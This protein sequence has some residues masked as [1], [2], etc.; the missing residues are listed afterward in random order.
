MCFSLFSVLKWS[1]QDTSLVLNEFKEHMKR[2][3]LPTFNEIKQLQR[4]NKSLQARTVASIK[5]MM[6]NKKK[7]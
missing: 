7:K 2:G 3:I 4:N 6:H 1:A 5:T